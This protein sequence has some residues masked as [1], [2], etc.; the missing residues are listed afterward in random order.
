[1]Q[2]KK[3]SNQLLFLPKTYERN[4]NDNELFN[5]I[6]KFIVQRNSYNYLAIRNRK[7][8]F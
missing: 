6:P 7:N 2:E 8:S 3:K 4:S 5:S 1:M